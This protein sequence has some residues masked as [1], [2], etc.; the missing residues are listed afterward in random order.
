M[1]RRTG[2]AGSVVV[3]VASVLIPLHEVSA[4][5]RVMAPPPPGQQ[6]SRTPPGRPI[7]IGTGPAEDRRATALTSP[8]EQWRHRTWDLVFDATTSPRSPALDERWPRPSDPI[9]WSMRGRAQYKTPKAAFT[10]SVIGQR[11]SQFPT[12]VTESLDAQGRYAISSG[13]LRE[14]FGQHTWDV[15][16]RLDRRLAETRGGVTL[17]AFAQAFHPV[18]SKARNIDQTPIACSSA[19]LFG[20]AIGF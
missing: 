5:Q 14:P 16:F 8:S 4:Q 2:G 17:D 15:A 1:Q 11:G 3:L 18:G 12:Y 19:L 20:V 13:A 6:E 7:D 10:A 9:A